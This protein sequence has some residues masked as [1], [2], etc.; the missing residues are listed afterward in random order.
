MEYRQR[1]DHAIQVDRP[2]AAGSHA[3][4]GQQGRRGRRSRPPDD[5]AIPGT[6]PDELESRLESVCAAWER[7][8]PEVARDKLAEALQMAH[9]LHYF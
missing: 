8:Q 6:A 7:D 1:V 5:R 4:G 9:D 2:L 3:P